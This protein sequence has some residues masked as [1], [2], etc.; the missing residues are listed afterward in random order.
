MVNIIIPLS[1]VTLRAAPLCP[2]K[3]V[4][5]VEFVFKDKVNMTTRIDR[6]SNSIRQ[7]GEN[8]GGRIVD[9]GVHG[10]Q[11]QS[12][13]MKFIQPIKSI[14]DEELA[15][16]SALAPA[17]VDR[18]APGSVVPA[19]EEL[20]CIHAQIISFRAKMVVDDIE[21]DH[22]SALMG[23]LHQFFKIFGTAIDAIW[24]VGE[25]TVVAPVA[26]SGKIGD[27]H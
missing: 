12:V 8:I 6:T 2:L 24:S 7:L 14:V 26:L 22:H 11:P 3:I 15:H 23:G 25:N 16:G 4:C 20:R 21:Q 13:E 18:V 10:I 27:G 17:E 9:D 19:G 5:L 1:G